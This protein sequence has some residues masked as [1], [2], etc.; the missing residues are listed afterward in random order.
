MLQAGGALADAASVIVYCTYQAQ[1]C[2][3]AG[4]LGARGVGA[5]AYHGGKAMQVPPPHPRPCEGAPPPLLLPAP[6]LHSPPA[7]C[8][9][10]RVS[11]CEE[12]PG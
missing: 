10:C 11:P 9:I 4:F 5:A 2:E 12:H 1:A 7:P 6:C 3:V 8:R